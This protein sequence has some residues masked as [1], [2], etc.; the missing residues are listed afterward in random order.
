MAIETNSA[1]T[2]IEPDIDSIAER[3]LGLTKEVSRLVVLIGAPAH[4][5]KSRLSRMLKEALTLMGIPVTTLSNDMWF[6]GINRPSHDTRGTNMKEVMANVDAA[7]FVK[8]VNRLVGGEVVNPPIY[9][10]KSRMHVADEGGALSFSEGV[11]ILDGSVVLAMRELREISS[12]KIYVD[13]PDHIRLGWLRQCKRG[14]KEMSRTE[15]WRSIRTSQRGEAPIAIAS[16][17]HAD[18]IYRQ[19]PDHLPLVVECDHR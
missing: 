17:T 8:T 3:I 15:T 11:L 19:D 13:I 7:E 16:A 12:L 18:L 14:F 10:F 1:V 5:G 4:S 2:T 9:D 6:G